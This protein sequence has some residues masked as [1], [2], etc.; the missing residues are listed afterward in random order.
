MSGKKPWDYKKVFLLEWRVEMFIVNF[1]A[2]MWQGLRDMFDDPGLCLPFWTGTVS[3]S[4]RDGS[5]ADGIHQAFHHLK[6]KSGTEKTGKYMNYIENTWL[7]N[8]IWL[9]NSCSQY[10][11]S[12]RTSND[13]EGWHN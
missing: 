7:N 12:I 2:G 8:H 9:V 1:E 5:T 6:A 13:C 11:R 10:G 3:Q 4:A